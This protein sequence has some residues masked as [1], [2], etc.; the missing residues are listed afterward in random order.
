MQSIKDIN[1]EIKSTFEVKGLIQVYEEIAATKMQKIRNSVTASSDYFKGLASLSDEVA[2][3]LAAGFGNSGSKFAAVFL[4][5]DTGLYGDIIDKIMVS[6]VDFIKKE[7]VD[8]FVA[9]SLG[10][11]L[12]NSYAPEL[13]VPLLPFLADKEDLDE[14]DL[15]VLMQTLNPYTKIYLFHGK[16]ESMARQNVLDSVI[17]GP[18]ISKY[19]LD[20]KSKKEIEERRFINIY[21]PDVNKVGQKFAHEISASVLDA[22][23]KE[24]QLAKYA[25]RLMHLDS[26]VNNI[27]EK[28]DKLDGDKK[29]MKKKIEAKKQTERTAR[30]HKV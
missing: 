18:D 9:G 2:L 19:G 26:A 14:N 11:S 10:Q 30:W 3:D 12:L 5:A 27:D 21:E 17:S 23:I 16:F 28:L 29:R 8:A 25:A 24:N 15:S 22:S 20:G 13:K 6:F 7:K 4:S 1:I